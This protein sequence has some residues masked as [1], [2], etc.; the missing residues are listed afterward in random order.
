[1]DGMMEQWR[2]KEHQWARPRGPLFVVE[3]G[4]VARLASSS[5]DLGDTGTP[6][7]TASVGRSTVTTGP[8]NIDPS[9]DEHAPGG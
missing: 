1:M 5:E 3:V 4:T 7:A 8:P 2:K 9:L 6:Q